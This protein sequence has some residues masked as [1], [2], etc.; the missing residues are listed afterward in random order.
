MLIVVED[1]RLPRSLRGLPVLQVANI[2]L[3]EQSILDTWHVRRWQT[4]TREIDQY[5]WE[6]LN[7]PLYVE[8]QSTPRF[9][10]G[11]SEDEIIQHLAQ[12]LRLRGA[13]VLLPGEKARSRTAQAADLIVWDEG[14]RA[15]F[16]LPLPIEILPWSGS[17]SWVRSQVQDTLVR[18]GA[19]SIVAVTPEGA[20]KNDLWSDGDKLI[21]TVTAQ[22]LQLALEGKTVADA[23]NSLLAAASA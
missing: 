9:P 11:S 8:I 5:A 7:K 21:L 6:A 12:D 16:G 22:S 2:H 23:F 4:E 18:S 20:R 13:R 10:Y 1:P 3:L 19:K 17:V 14:L 15:A